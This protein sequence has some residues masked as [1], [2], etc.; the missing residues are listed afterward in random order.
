MSQDYKA[1]RI[2][3]Q[4]IGDGIMEALGGNE[5]LLPKDSGRR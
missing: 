4:N 2:V 3:N 5:V 1:A